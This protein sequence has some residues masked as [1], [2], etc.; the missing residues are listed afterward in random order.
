MTE[1]LQHVLGVGEHI[2]A[3]HNRWSL[4]QNIGYLI[5]KLTL[6]HNANI[7]LGY[8]GHFLSVRSDN[9]RG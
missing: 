2:G 8:R 4:T 3:V 9:A 6:A 1:L 5:E 7:L